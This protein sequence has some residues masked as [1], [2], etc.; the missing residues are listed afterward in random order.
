MCHEFLLIFF[1]LHLLAATIDAPTPG[2]DELL[3]MEEKFAAM[4]AKSEA[5][6]Q[7]VH[8]A[9]IDIGGELETKR[10]DIPSTTV[11]ERYAPIGIKDS[12]LASKKSS[13]KLKLL[14]EFKDEV[15]TTRIMNARNY[16][17]ITEGLKKP[18]K[19]VLTSS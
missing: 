6:T 17:G 2:E 12:I 3:R 10:T 7:S 9:A 13:V 8:D 15:R 18:E 11:S 5:Q 4:K 16:M 1:Y 14:T 19:K